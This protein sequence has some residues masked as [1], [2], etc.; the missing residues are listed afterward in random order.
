MT[1]HDEV[2][3][4]YVLTDKGDIYLQVP[5]PSQRWGFYLADD[6]QSWDGGVGI[7]KDWEVLAED[8]P[9]ITPEIA[10]RLSWMIDDFHFRTANPDDDDAEVSR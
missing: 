1:T 6:E 7:A 10:D 8:D 2:A 5:D 9:R 3:L 4:G